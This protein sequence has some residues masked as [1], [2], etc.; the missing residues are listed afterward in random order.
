[1]NVPTLESRCKSKQT[2]LKTKQNKK[3]LEPKPHVFSCGVGIPPHGILR[4]SA[5]EEKGTVDA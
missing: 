5:D 2:S 3:Y 4:L 1:M